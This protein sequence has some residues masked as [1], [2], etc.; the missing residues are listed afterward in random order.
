M[1]VAHFT[2]E[3]AS[4]IVA[5]RLIREAAESKPES[6]SMIA[7]LMQPT[8]QRIVEKSK[9]SRNEIGPVM[10]ELH[11]RL[12]DCR[13]VIS[14]QL[15]RRSCSAQTRLSANETYD[16]RFI[17][18][19]NVASNEKHLDFLA[20]T[21]SLSRKELIIR[22]SQ[23][24]FKVSD[25][26]LMRWMTR[27][28]KHG[29]EFF[30]EIIRAIRLSVILSPLTT[31]AGMRN[32]ALTHEN[33]LLLGQSYVLRES[34]CDFLRPVQIKHSRQGCDS[35]LLPIVTLSQG[36]GYVYNLR[37]YIDEPSLTSIKSEI[38]QKLHDFESRN[39]QALHNCFEAIVF[40]GVNRTHDTTDEIMRA[41]VNAAMIDAKTMVTSD[42]WR[43]W[44]K[45]V[46][47]DHN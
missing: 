36:Y 30:S 32:I 41:G 7:A 37:T 44:S 4:T 23:T 10:E 27:E 22:V 5:R 21:A 46:A 31:A 35:T 1:S 20:C 13:N 18:M 40:G 19:A 24:G 28:Q 11:K 42:L 8:A 38:R 15:W 3:T 25:H 6:L 29:P 17:F 33:G 12:R 43:K 14:L 16:L 2:S 34:D 47:E 45:S 9:I 26:A 39:K